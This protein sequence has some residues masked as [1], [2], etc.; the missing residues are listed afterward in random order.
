[1]K[2]YAKVMALSILVIATGLLTA[3]GSARADRFDALRN[4]ER[5]HNGLL[6]ITIGRHIE[7]TC[8]SIERRS[9]AAN[10]FLLGLASHAMGLGYS[11]ADVTAYVEDD[12]EQERYIALARSYFAERGVADD[13]DTDGAC[14]VGRDEI[15]AG[16]PIGRLLR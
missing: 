14:R 16:S 1:M 12:A 15:A 8:P 2:P 9:L 4:D 7:R 11:R 13:A 10:A 3:A 6:A 5:L